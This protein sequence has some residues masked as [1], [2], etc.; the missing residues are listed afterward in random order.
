MTVVALRVSFTRLPAAGVVFAARAD[1]RCALGA[2]F[3]ITLHAVLAPAEKTPIAAALTGVCTGDTSPIFA[4]S[5]VATIAPAGALELFVSRSFSAASK[6]RQDHAHHERAGHRPPLKTG[7]QGHRNQ[8][9]QEPMSAQ[10]S[11]AALHPESHWQLALAEKGCPHLPLQELVPPLQRFPP[12]L[13][14]PP[15]SVL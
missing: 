11:P 13:P 15:H 1:N 9:Q 14:P 7:R 5:F 10:Q 4:R 6:R 8:G 12:L 3:A 2:G